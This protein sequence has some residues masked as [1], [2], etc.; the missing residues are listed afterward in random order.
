MDL[1]CNP[2]TTRPIQTGWEFTIEPYP[3]W[4]LGY[5]DH[6]DRRFGKGSVWTRTRAS[7]DSPEPFLTLSVIV[8][9]QLHICC[10]QNAA[11]THPLP[12][13]VPARVPCT[14]H[15]WKFRRPPLP[16]LSNQIELYPH[17]WAVACRSSHAFLLSN[18]F[19]TFDITGRWYVHSV[20]WTCGNSPLNRE[21]HQLLSYHRAKSIRLLLVSLTPTYALLLDWSENP[22]IQSH[23]ETIHSLIFSV[24][25]QLAANGPA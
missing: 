1:L 21:N 24:C 2:L 23:P 19:C 3:S 15:L 8:L 10:R 14:W 12:P 4:Q 5:I 9:L 16:P 7:S 11:H 20:V 25:S 22:K 13:V 6:P 17:P 18:S